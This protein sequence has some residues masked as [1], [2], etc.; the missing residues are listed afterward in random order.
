MPLADNAHRRISI[1]AFGSMSVAE[2]NQLR[3]DQEARDGAT[4][5]M[6]ATVCASKRNCLSIPTGFD[7]LNTLLSR[8]IFAGHKLF[9]KKCHHFEEV[10]RMRQELRL[11]HWRNMNTL[12]QNDVASLVWDVLTDATQFFN[13]FLSEDEFSADSKVGMPTS[14]LQV[15]R[16][17]LSTNLHIPSLDTTSRWLLSIPLYNRGGGGLRKNLRT[18]QARC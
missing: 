13:T 3:E 4:A 9:T 7:D 6:L 5:L 1:L 16:N 12:P 15:R 2:E 8:Y 10:V 14:N 18:N 11:M 17:L